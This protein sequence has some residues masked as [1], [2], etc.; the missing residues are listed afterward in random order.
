MDEPAAK[1]F[2]WTGAFILAIA[3]GAGIG[4]AI[5]AL[6]IIF[7]IVLHPAFGGL[8]AGVVIGILMVRRGGS[9]RA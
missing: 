7:G 1:R 2:D 6:K 5:A 3:I 8:I 9:R 4:L